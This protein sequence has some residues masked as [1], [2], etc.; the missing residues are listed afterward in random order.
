MKRQKKDI[1][2]EKLL[3]LNM[4]FEDALKKGLNTS[5]SK[6]KKNSPREITQEDFRKE[7]Q[8]NGEIR[9]QL[10]NTPKSDEKYPL[11]E[12]RI[13]MSDKRLVRIST[14]LQKENK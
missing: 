14:H 2:Q 1:K 11:L 4:T 12:E 8:K 7:M 6:S 13:Q 3:K 10:E 9:K 5:L